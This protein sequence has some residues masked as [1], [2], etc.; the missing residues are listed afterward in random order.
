MNMPGGNPPGGWQ[1]PPAGAPPQ[2]QAP[3]GQAPQGHAPQGYAPQGHAPQGQ[4]PQGPPGGFGSPPGGPMGPGGGGPKAPQVAVSQIFENLKLLFGRSTSGILPAMAALA[5][6]ALL[7]AVPSWVMNYLRL[8]ALAEGDF[9]SFWAQGVGQY[10]GSLMTL[11]AAVLVGAL[12]VGIYRPIRRVMVEGPQAVAGPG[13]ALKQ[14][15]QGYGMNIAAYL[16]VGVAMFFGVLACFVP[17]FVVMFFVAFVP[18]LVA[19]KGT[20]VI[21]SFKLSTKYAMNQ[22]PALLA[23]LGLIVLLV[24]VFACC[25]GAGGNAAAVSMFGLTGSAVALPFMTILGEVVALFWWLF[26]GATLVTL[27]TAETGTPI[28]G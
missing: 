3:Q 27:E 5:A 21:E 9:R 12:R 6:L 17:V 28:Q 1:P 7:L 23:A 13:D 15:A 20:D 26:L 11:V 24:V 22:A 25:I 19:A 18:Y 2:G 14:A 4:A 16:L 8:S 10:C